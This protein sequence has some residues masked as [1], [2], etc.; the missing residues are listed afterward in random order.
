MPGKDKTIRPPA[1][2][3][4]FYDRNPADLKR[5]VLGLLGNVHLPVKSSPGYVRAL[6]VPHAGYYYSGQTAAYAYGAVKDKEYDAVIV[7]GPSHRK[8]FRGI[9][10]FPGDAYRTPLGDVVVHKELRDELVDRNLGIEL[11]ENGHED[12]HSIE[13]QLPFLQLLYGSFEFVP[14]IMGDQ[15]SDFVKKLAK[16]LESVLKNKNVLLVASTDLSHYHPYET[17]MIMDKRLI[18]SVERYNPD[19]LMSR[20][21]ERSVEACGGGP[22]VSVMQA[23]KLLG[24]KKAS[25]LNYCTSGDVSGDKSAV[26]GYLAASL[27]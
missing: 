1:V 10:V 17:A 7:V 18:S 13:V 23:S 15:S 3:G 19:E 11:S 5:T 12:E 20:I 26:V 9:S 25:V 24:C 6:I 21:E 14:V 27:S 16:K 2:S 22:M 4:L 8:Y